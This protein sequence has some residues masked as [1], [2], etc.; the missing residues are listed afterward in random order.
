MG[1]LFGLLT[2]NRRFRNVP[3]SAVNEGVDDSEKETDESSPSV[4]RKSIPS[5]RGESDSKKTIAL[6]ALSPDYDARKL[7]NLSASPNELFLKEPRDERW[8]SQIERN[9]KEII[10]S[11]FATVLPQ[12]KLSTV[13]CRTMIC[14]VRIE[15]DTSD[16]LKK[17]RHLAGYSPLADTV[18]FG[19]TRMS[20]EGKPSTSLTLVFG[21]EHRDPAEYKKWYSMLREQNFE[22]LRAR[23][24]FRPKDFPEVPPL[25]AR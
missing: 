5:F 25:E 4:V 15:A 3:R 14:K 21:S 2:T 13:E 23:E 12:A 9:L 18:S 20:P 22:K 6:S 11:D 1:V 16:S 24:A 19:G 17:V 7:V 8:A 10:S